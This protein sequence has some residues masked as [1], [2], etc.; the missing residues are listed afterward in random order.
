[1]LRALTANKSQANAIWVQSVSQRHLLQ[2][3]WRRPCWLPWIRRQMP[4]WQ[5]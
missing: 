5:A 1:M 3:Q 2:Q 4:H